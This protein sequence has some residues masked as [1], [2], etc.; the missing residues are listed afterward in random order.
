[1]SSS[2]AKPA[3]I[4]WTHGCLHAVPRG[5]TQSRPAPSRPTIRLLVNRSCVLVLRRDF[6]WSSL[7]ILQAGIKPDQEALT[8][9]SLACQLRLRTVS[10]TYCLAPVKKEI[11]AALAQ[12][13]Q[14]HHARW[15][16]PGAFLPQERLREE[17][18]LGQQVDGTALQ[19]QPP[20]AVC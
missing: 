8:V 5:H 4:P 7:P 1:M 18:S 2:E 16:T 12:S 9:Q 6:L 17:W 20:R 15:E 14:M 3:V 19:N 10:K 13:E 11:K